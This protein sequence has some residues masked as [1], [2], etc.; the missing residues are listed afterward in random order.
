MGSESLRQDAD[1]ELTVRRG[2]EMH[3]MQNYEQRGRGKGAQETLLP[4]A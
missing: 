1:K 2:R 4:A 3:L